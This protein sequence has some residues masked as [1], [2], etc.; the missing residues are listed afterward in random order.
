[1]PSGSAR[2]EVGEGER[3]QNALVF[4]GTGWQEGGV[5]GWYTVPAESVRPGETWTV[6]VHARGTEATGNN[7]VALAWYDGDGTWLGNTTS[8][9]LRPD[10]PGWQ[11]LI[12]RGAAP[13]E[14]RG[15]TIHLRSEGNDGEVA[16]SG[17]RW[18]VA[19]S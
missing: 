2:V 4:S 8:N 7:D 16:Y 18:T 15:V 1:M 5:T 17:V 9:P 12:A 3:G 10:V 14:A 11:V 19:A 6:T 13:A